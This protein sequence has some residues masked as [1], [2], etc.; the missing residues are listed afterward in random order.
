MRIGQLAKRS[1]LMVGVWDSAVVS[2][3]GFLTN[4]LAGRFLATSDYGLFF[5]AFIVANMGMLI[6]S[7]FISSP[8]AILAPRMDAAKR[9]EYLAGSTWIT[10][11]SAIA[12]GIVLS[13][14][15]FFFF[16]KTI[17]GT[18]LAS[19]LSIFAFYVATVM[20]QDFVRRACFAHRREAA[21]LLLDIVSAGGQVALLV[22][23]RSYMTLDLAL[24]VISGTTALGVAAVYLGLLRDKSLPF[25]LPP[26]RR[27][28]R[29]NIALGKWL[30]MT[31]GASWIANQI[32]ILAVAAFQ[33]PIV[34]AQLG[35]AR[36]IAAVSNPAVMT[37]DNMGTPRASRIAHESG[38]VAL[39][40]FIARI[41]LIG[42]V[43]FIAL[44]ALCFVYPNEA[45]RILFHRSFGEIRTLVRI[46]SLMPF[47]WFAGRSIV[48]GINALKK[49][50]ALFPV[51]LVIAMTTM[52]VGVYLARHYGAL[53]AAYG[54]LFNSVLMVAG[55]LIQFLRLTRAEAGTTKA[56]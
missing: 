18:G 27:A 11:G 47:L 36:T 53:G 19:V 16:R 13:A 7:S 2:L 54:L 49:P 14:A 20:L 3:S 39:R 17:A 35:A 37:V 9:R 40:G 6:Q 38:P 15:M 44:G 41:T 55:F 5:T 29:D 25:D 34:V 10:C 48:V 46:F 1:F 50:K 31:A 30:F 22:A 43:P 56:N 42:C 26:M 21:A 12:V 28:M 23:L 32:Y 52:T 4:V 8:Y 24:I 33:T 45:I 51:Y